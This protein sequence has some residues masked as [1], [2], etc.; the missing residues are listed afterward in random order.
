MIVYIIY[1][2]FTILFILSFKWEIADHRRIRKIPCISKIKGRKQKKRHYRL[3]AKFPYENAVSWRMIYITSVFI[4]LIIWF[5]LHKSGV[6][7]NKETLLVIFL[8]IFIGFQ[9]SSGFTSFH[10]YRMIASKA[11]PHIVTI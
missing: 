5:V 2:A 8:S 10:F 6:L 11:D 3:L 4:A 1:M 9:L 7:L